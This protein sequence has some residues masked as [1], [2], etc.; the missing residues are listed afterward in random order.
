MPRPLARPPQDCWEQKSPPRDPTTNQLR[1]D[2]KRFPSGMKALGDYV[3]AAGLSFA[4]Y[5]AESSET[6]GGYPASKDYETIDA[7]T[8][9]SWGVECVRAHARAAA[10]RRPREVRLHCAHPPSSAAAASATFAPRVSPQLP[11]GGR[12]RRQLLLP[13]RL[14]RH[15]RG[16]R[17]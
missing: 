14:Q 1:G 6:C 7:Q 17:G 9:A 16:A 15:G 4:M 8:F 11:Q 13:A 5:T 10:Q 3:H 12:L 2:F